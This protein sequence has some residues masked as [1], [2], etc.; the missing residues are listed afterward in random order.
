MKRVA[1]WAILALFGAAAIFSLYSL[2]AQSME[3]IRALKL[4]AAAVLFPV[5]FVW[6]MWIALSWITEKNNAE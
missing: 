1:G 6:V 2:M 4:T 3:P 5:G